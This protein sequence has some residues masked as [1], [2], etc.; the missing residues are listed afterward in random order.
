MD[1]PRSRVNRR[2]WPFAVGAAGLLLLGT[3]GLRGL[4]SAPPTVERASIVLDTVRRGDLVLAVQGQGSLV[5]ERIQWVSAV[6]AGQVERVLLTPGTP[7][8]TDTLL[9]VLSNPNLELQALEAER[10]LVTASSELANLQAT[11]RSHRLAQQSIIASLSSDQHE[12]QLRAEAD[13]ELSRK[14]FLSALEMSHSSA[15]AEELAG[16]VEFERKRLE[17]LGEGLAAQRAAQR[18]QIDRLQSIADFRRQQVQALRVR[19]RVSGVLQELPLQAG[20][21]ITP[22]T[23]LGKIVEPE[24]LK[25]ELR[26]SQTRMKD[27]QIGQSATIDTRL[28]LVPGRVARIDP[29]VREGVVKVDVALEG[30]LPKGA[31]PDLNVEGTIELERLTHVLFVGRPISPRIDGPTSLFRVA[32]DGRSA[33]R[34]SVQ[35][36]RSSVRAVEVLS[37]L[38]EAD[39]IILSEL[40][41]WDSAQK[42][43]LR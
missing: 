43:V 25:A 17:A 20:Q 26:I 40:P 18:A 24:K 35:L 41:Q 10:Q 39:Q 12:A 15:K 22:G 28:G 6:S 3:L 33:D 38:A 4:K 14:G 34:V 21:W 30:P 2:R 9:V 19:A 16:R 36:G 37:G 11:Q 1:V 8:E 29:S 42:I 31:R 5:P 13:L 23:V 27:V 32:P 7:V